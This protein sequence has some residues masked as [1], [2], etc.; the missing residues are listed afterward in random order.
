MYNPVSQKS[1]DEL[2]PQE[3]AKLLATVKTHRKD[4]PLDWVTVAEILQHT[5]SNQELAKR[6]GVTPRLVGMIKGLLSLPEEIKTY[7]RTKQIDSLDKA[8]RIASLKNSGDQLF[9]SKAIVADPSTFTAPIVTKAVALRNG[10]KDISIAE[11]IAR[12]LKSKPIRENR[13]VLVTTIGKSLSENASER[14]TKQGT[15]FLDFL[16]GVVRQSLLSDKDLLSL[17]THNGLILLTLTPDGWQALRQKSGSLGVPL[18][19]L[20]ET[21]LRHALESQPQ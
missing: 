16:K 4:R 3:K 21:L 1:I 18:D 11:C 14:L 6:L 9:L 15:S 17:A 13:Y 5:T 20:I 10:N 19:E 7:V 12:V 8:V 2:S